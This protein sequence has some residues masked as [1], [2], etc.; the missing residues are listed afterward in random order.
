MLEN[1]RMALGSLWSNKLRALL[2]MLGIIIGI[3][4][5]IAIVTV[6]N[7]LTASVSDSMSGLGAANLTVSLTQKSTDEADAAAQG[8]A[9]VRMFGPSAPGEEDLLTDAMIA[10]YRAAFGDAVQAIE[11]TETLGRGTATNG[12]LSAAVQA[13]GVNEEYAAAEE[14]ELLAGRFVRD[15]DGERQVAVV[16]DAFLEDAFGGTLTPQSALGQRFT[17]SV[18]G[19][20]LGFYILGVYHYEEEE[21]GTISLT[22]F[23]DETVTDLYLPLAAAK[24]LA[25]SAA[26]YQ[27]FTVVGSAEADT[28]QFMEATERFFASYYSRNPSY[29]AAASSLASL[30]ETMTEMLGTI[31]LAVSAIAAISLLVGGIGVMNIMLVSIT[32]RTR[33]IGIRKALGAKNSA[34]RLQFVVEAVLICL[35]G[36]VLGILV[37]VA[38][39]SLGAQMMGASAHVEVSTILLA[40]GFSMSIGVFFGAY[41]AGKAAKMDPIEALRYE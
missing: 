15:S 32:E 19:R 39:G 23:S 36:G 22:A 21:T 5:V 27:S 9:Q 2:T 25:G 30:L 34:I 17:L 8:S 35:I 31:S 37:G 11:L 16:S 33:E 4:S 41:P 28:E 6:G 1:I 24:K 20:L 14:V 26:G 12:A 38:L 13:I 10:E 40:V 3:G 29:T 7:S 18:N